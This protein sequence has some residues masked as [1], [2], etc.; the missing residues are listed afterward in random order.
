MQKRLLKNAE[1]NY[2]KRVLDIVQFGSSVIEGKEPRDIDIAV[3]FDKLPV[4]EQLEEAQ[5]IKKQLKSYFDKEVHI[6]AFDLC[7]FFD[8]GN[9]SRESILFYGISLIDGS[10][11]SEKFGLDSKIQIIYSLEDLHKRD[12]IRFNYLLSGKSGKYGLLR[13]Y[14]GYLL[15]PG[16]IEIPPGMEEIFIN[17]IRKIT[18]KF[19]VKKVFYT[20]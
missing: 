17:E 12:K 5:I 2:S 11:F 7:S 1:L 8:E 13:K 10:K 20:K 3:I 9:F 15:A 6:N 4:K 19:K 18:S 14:N 16:V